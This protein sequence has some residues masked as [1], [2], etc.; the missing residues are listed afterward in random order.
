LGFPAVLV[1]LGHGQN[2]FLSAALIGGALALLDKRPVI[3]GIL[4]GLLSYKPQF[5][6]LIPLAL[7]ADG[8]WRA[9]LSAAVTVAIL[10]AATTLAFG[11]EIWSAFFDST[12]P[13]RVIILEAGST[14]WQKIQSVFSWVRMWGGSV[15]LAYAAQAVATLVAA[16][17]TVWVWR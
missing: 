2:G 1:N 6:V 14:G 13:T 12:R 4:F 15:P 3:A 11:P 5:G 17:G 10:V 9:F 7:I 16:V 8:R